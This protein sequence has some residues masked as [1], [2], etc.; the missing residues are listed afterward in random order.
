MRRNVW[1]ERIREHVLRRI[2]NFK[3]DAELSV[4]EMGSEVQEASRFMRRWFCWKWASRGAWLANNINPGAKQMEGRISC[5]KRIEIFFRF[6][7]GHPRALQACRATGLQCQN[8]W[9]WCEPIWS[10]SSGFLIA[11]PG[12]PSR[13]G[14]LRH[15]DSRV[16]K[17][18]SSQS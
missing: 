9:S 14:S 18:Q 13:V 7:A 10:L 11:V 3:L 17:G 12:I 16:F 1:S 15:R 6:G 2:L 8:Y 4:K 5:S